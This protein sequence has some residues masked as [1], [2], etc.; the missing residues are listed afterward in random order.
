MSGCDLRVWE[1]VISQAWSP[2]GLGPPGS[3]RF[4]EIRTASLVGWA[5]ISPAKLL[6]ET[7]GRGR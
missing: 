1:I 2:A 5:Q 6:A 7:V 3:S 4:L